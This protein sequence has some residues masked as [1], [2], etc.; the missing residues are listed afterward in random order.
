M[1][2]VLELVGIFVSYF[3]VLN[4]FMVICSSKFSDVPI[5]FFLPMSIPMDPSLPMPIP[6]FLPMP[7]QIP[8][9]ADSCLHV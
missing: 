3:E 7:M 5:P 1:S 4:F 2:A 8:A 9:D 6:I